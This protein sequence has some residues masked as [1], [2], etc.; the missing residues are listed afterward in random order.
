MNKTRRDHYDTGRVNAHRSD[1]THNMLQNNQGTLHK[2]VRVG[3]DATAMVLPTHRPFLSV[4]YAA[5][6]GGCSCL[7]HRARWVPQPYTTQ[8]THGQHTLIF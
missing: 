1:V 4:A 8:T 7:F 6:H 5:I 2:I 3:G